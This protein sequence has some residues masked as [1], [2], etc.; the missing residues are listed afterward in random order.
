MHAHAGGKLAVL[1][2]RTKCD[3]TAAKLQIGSRKRKMGLGA[4]QVV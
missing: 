2:K 4:R 1:D 3:T